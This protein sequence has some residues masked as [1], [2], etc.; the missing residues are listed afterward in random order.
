MIR[1]L[2][3]SVEALLWSFVVILFLQ[4]C[5]G[6]TCCQMLSNYMQDESQDPEQRIRVFELFGTFNIT[7]F[8]MFQV[9][10]ASW[11][12]PTKLLMEQVSPW[13]G[14]YFI[15][16]R[17][18][19]FYAFGKV[20]SAVFICETQ[21]LVTKD[22][23]L[24]TLKLQE[25]AQE[26]QLEM[27]AMFDELDESGDGR[28]SR[29]ELRQMSTSPKVVR[30]SKKLGVETTQFDDL[31]DLLESPDG[32]IHKEGFLRGLPKLRGTA[33]SLELFALHQIVRQMA[34]D[35]ESL[36]FLL[37]LS[38]ARSM[39]EFG[40]ALGTERLTGG[41]C[42]QQRVNPRRGNLDL[43]LEGEAGINTIDAI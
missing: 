15:L 41:P 17:C 12:G 1:S 43:D 40:G 30:E 36:K 26:F 19:L 25:R 8:T 5:S 9:T 2:L 14:L 28:L 22:H 13:W 18:V 31:F 27:K 39:T 38:N 21:R 23:E 35:V 24:Q 4:V 29:S 11:V 37:P 10:F 42:S 7:M 6:L 34:R 32:Y 3:A 16:Y 20:I 33:S